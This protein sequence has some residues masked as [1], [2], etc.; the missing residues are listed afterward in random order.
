MKLNKCNSLLDF[1]NQ[2]LRG[3]I[4]EMQSSKTV[5]CKLQ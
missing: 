2:N 3:S 4:D 5:Q 1:K